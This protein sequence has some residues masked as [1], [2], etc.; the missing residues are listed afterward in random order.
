MGAGEGRQ[1][2]RRHAV[3]GL[4]QGD[5]AAG[6]A[7]R[8][9]H[10]DPGLHRLLERLP[11]RDLADL[12]RQRRAPCPAAMSYFTGATTFEKPDRRRSPPPRSS[13]R[14]RSSS[15]C[16][17]SSAAS[18]PAS[19]PA[20]SRAEARDRQQGATR[21]RDRPG[22]R[23]QALP[24]RRARPSTTS[25]S[26]S[27]TA[28]SSSWSGPRAAGSR[29]RCNMI[30]GLEDITEGELRIDGKVVNDKAPKDRDIAMVFQS[31]ALYPHMTVRR[32][33]GLPARC[34]PGSTRPR[35]RPRSTRP[36]RCSS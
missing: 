5:R 25:T 14:S 1:D 7:R 36:P 32:E 28:S 34:W 21:G 2:G 27:P 18:S 16:C 33:H 11:V 9:H 13:S 30:A 35:S 26:T 6:H 23:R 24:R 12:D 10:G 8:L 15:S 19:R 29:P 20:R 4:P 31:Y 22:P 17:S 3:P